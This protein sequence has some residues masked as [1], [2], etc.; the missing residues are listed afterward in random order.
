MP[1]RKKYTKAQKAAYAR[2][3]AKRRRGVSKRRPATKR[4]T[5]RWTAKANYFTTSMVSR[6]GRPMQLLPNTRRVTLKYTNFHLNSVTDIPAAGYFVFNYAGNGL[7]DPDITGVGGQPRGF[8]QLAALYRRYYVIKSNIE[9]SFAPDA[10]SVAG[11]FCGVIPQAS[12]ATELTKVPYYGTTSAE[13][14][15]R[16]GGAEQFHNLPRWSITQM[17]F[18]HANASSTMHRRASTRGILDTK[19]IDRSDLQALVTANP[20]ELWHWTVI[21]G[22]LNEAAQTDVGTILVKL[23][24]DCIFM[25]PVVSADS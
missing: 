16:V 5:N 15:T 10:D 3:M 23:S 19:S 17:P 25:D 12:S 9:V 6:V 22:A 13:I 8:D 4:M 21:L 7:F 14:A 2:R 24:Y 11:L 18:S 1:Y 20:V